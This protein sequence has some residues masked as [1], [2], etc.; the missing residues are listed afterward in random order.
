MRSLILSLVL[1]IGSVGVLA[2]VPSQAEARS[3]RG[4]Y[5]YYPGYASYSPRASYY[6]SGPWGY[7]AYSYGR[8]AGYRPPFYNSYYHWGYPTYYYSR[9]AYGFSYWR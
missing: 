4:G 6:Y 2:L 3:W 7:P 1:G 5:Y 9:P 8:Y